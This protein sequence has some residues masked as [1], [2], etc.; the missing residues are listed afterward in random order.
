MWV[1]LNDAMV[2]AVSDPRNKKQLIV[3]ARLKGD[4]ERLF[5][6]NKVHETPGRDY[7]FR[8]YVGRR[9]FAS[10]LFQ[11]A[12]D[13]DYGNF[14]NSVADNARHDAYTNVWGAMHRAQKR[15]QGKLPLFGRER[16]SMYSND[17]D[18]APWDGDTIPAAD[19]DFGT[20]DWSGPTHRRPV[21]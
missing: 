6:R 21:G 19:H 20:P 7:R 11:R 8:V 15:E 14:K 9:T 13:I 1:F 3:R 5:P 17:D 2:S 10:R 16:H 18:D 12:M 4:L